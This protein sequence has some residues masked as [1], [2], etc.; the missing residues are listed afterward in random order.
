MQ[1]HFQVHFALL[2]LHFDYLYPSLEKEMS[3]IRLNI[4]S[5]CQTISR[6]TCSIRVFVRYTLKELESTFDR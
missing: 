3:Y 1:D 5:D 6:T 2:L 4:K